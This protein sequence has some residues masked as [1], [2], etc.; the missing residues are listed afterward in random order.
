MATKIGINGFGRIG[1]SVM[2]A[3][4]QDPAFE[5]A[6]VNDL[7]DAK[8]LAHLLKYDTVH[9]RFPGT[10]EADGATMIINGKKTLVTSEREPGKLPWKA[11]GVELVI[12]STGRFTD[13]KGCQGHLDAGAR[14]VIISAPAKDPD[15][16][17]A[18]GI[19][20]ENYDAA[21]HHIV[22]NASCTTNCL[23]PVA[24]VLHESFGIV[25]GLM[26]TVHSYTNDQRILD[27]QHDDPRRARAAAMNM[28]PT[29]TG[30]AKA[31]SL[32]LPAM[33][34]KLDGQAIRVPTMNVSLV[35]LTAQI[36]KKADKKAINDAYKAAAAGPLKGILQVCEEPLVSMD[37][38]GDKHSA[39]LD[40]ACT[41]VIADNMVKVM[42]W[43][44]NE[45]GYSQ[46]VY[47]LSKFIV[48][49]GW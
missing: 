44:D 29:S 7:T 23:A 36:E 35:D 43:Y 45:S 49:K 39:S 28:I 19:N 31:L 47:D 13:K 41:M 1:R 18:C 11:H 20:L 3:F 30:A 21:K 48:S 8:A 34:G 26:T 42:A 38:N 25:R 2:R 37:F 40:A 6:V 17:L 24:K 22:S 12:E 16:T 15:I 46:R 9:G 4:A 33:A 27:L 14:K 5:V 32:V 10:V